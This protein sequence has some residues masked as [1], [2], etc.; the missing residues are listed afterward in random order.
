MSD[1]ESLRTKLDEIVARVTSLEEARET[2]A[3]A[4]QY[5]VARPHPWRKQLSVKGRNLSVGQLLGTVRANGLTIEQ[6]AEAFDLP[7][8]AIREAIAYGE[9]NRALIELEAAEERSR[10]ARKGYKLEPEPLPR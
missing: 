6:A 9:Q 5:L 10:L 2:P 8:N 1:L 4:W 7:P 3:G